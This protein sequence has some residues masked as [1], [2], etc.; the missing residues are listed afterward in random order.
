MICLCL[1]FLNE[2]WDGVTGK[3]FLNNP[4]KVAVCSVWEMVWEALLLS[5]WID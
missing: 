4:E 5:V 2:F 1:I 3:T